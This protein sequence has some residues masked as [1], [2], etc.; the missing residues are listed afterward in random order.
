MKKSIASCLCYVPTYRVHKMLL[1]L[2]REWRK[3][4]E[5]GVLEIGGGWVV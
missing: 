2:A 5:K 3:E 1:C 4:K